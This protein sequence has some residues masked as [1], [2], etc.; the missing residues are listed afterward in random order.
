L[1][2]GEEEVN[3]D[4][5]HA[6]LESGSFLTEACHGASKAGGWHNDPRTG[7]PRTSDQNHELFPVRLMLIVSELSEAME[8]HRKSIMDDKLPHRK[9]SEVELADAAIRIFDLAGAMGYDLGGAIAEKIAFNAQRADHKIEN[10]LKPGG[11][12]Y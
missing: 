8:G 2:E 11:K 4:Q 12:A 1:H 3:N 9:M 5:Y 6:L 7:E 10:R